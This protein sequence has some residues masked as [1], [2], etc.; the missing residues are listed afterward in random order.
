MK[1]K[2][3]KKLEQSMLEIDKAAAEM[4]TLLPEEETPA[5]AQKKK[6]VVVSEAQ[7]PE[8]PVVGMT[9][10][11]AAQSLRVSPRTIQDMLS[12]GRLPGRLVG[13]KWRL[14]PKALD[15]FL[16]EYEHDTRE[17]DE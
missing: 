11:E 16:G 13:N 2:N 8:W 6:G 15:R 14:S 17:G 10:Q 3:G 5:Q 1:Q 9:V 7:E 12:Q 4:K